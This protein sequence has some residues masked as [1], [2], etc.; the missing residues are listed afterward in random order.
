MAFTQFDEFILVLVI[1]AAFYTYARVVDKDPDFANRAS[2]KIV[3]IGFAV[4]AMYKGLASR[5]TMDTV[6]YNVSS[7]GEAVDFSEAF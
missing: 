3:F 7:A 4:A 1:T 6:H 5:L 2:L